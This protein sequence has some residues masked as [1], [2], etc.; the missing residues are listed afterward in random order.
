MAIGTVFEYVRLC[1]GGWGGDGEEE[2][3]GDGR[4]VGV[5]DYNIG[6]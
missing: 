1:Q 4:K 6:G 5:Y 2:Q 3:V